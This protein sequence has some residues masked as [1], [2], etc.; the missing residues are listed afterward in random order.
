MQPQPTDADIAV[1]LRGDG[2]PQTAQGLM[3]KLQ[4]F[5]DAI[6]LAPDSFARGGTV[7][8]LEQ[9]CAEMLGKETSVFMPTGTLA[10]H[11]ALRQ[12]CG[13]KPR[14][15]VPEQSHLY[16][17]TGD[18]VPR[19]SG[20]HLVPLAPGRPYFTLDELRE[21]LLRSVTGRV[22]SPVGAVLI[23]SPMRRQHGQ[24]MPDAEM[25]AVAN[26]CTA[27]CIATHLDGARLYMMAA[28]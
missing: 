22:D 18:C 28:A 25:V 19:L 3:R 15:V 20:I 8:R 21:V 12:L 9:C 23:E 11:L 13:V 6:G 27:Q 7:E 4:A 16:N 2:E 1:V 26:Y 24:I 14:A 5:E 10:N 17:D